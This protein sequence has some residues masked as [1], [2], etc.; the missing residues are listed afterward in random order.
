MDVGVNIV[1]EPFDRLSHLDVSHVSIQHLNHDH[2]H[3]DDRLDDA[4]DE[5]HVRHSFHMTYI[6]NFLTNNT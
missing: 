5:V 3:G 6:R 4:D 2:E 1:F